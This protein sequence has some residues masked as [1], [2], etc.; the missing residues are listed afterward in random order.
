MKLKSFHGLLILIAVSI[1]AFF[2]GIYVVSSGVFSPLSETASTTVSTASVPSI[3]V[4]FPRAGDDAEGTLISQMNSATST[5]DVAIYEFTDSN[6]ADAIVSAEKRGVN[7]RVILDAGNTTD[8][9]ES[10][11]VSK[12]E[13]AG[14]PIVVNT[15]SGIMHL[16]VTVTDESVVSTGSYNYTSS[17]QKKN[18]E[19][20][21]TITD[22]AVAQIYETEFNRM[23]SDTSNYETLS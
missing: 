10:Q 7:V 14:I 21:V 15:H 5:M 12:L 1:V 13:D 3:S 20:L 17:A 6:I 22:S 11:N 4:E 23:W 16:K 2:A 9:Y 18:D 19:N 8:S